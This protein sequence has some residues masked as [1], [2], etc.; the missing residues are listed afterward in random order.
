LR[1]RRILGVLGALLFAAVLHRFGFRRSFEALLAADRV[2]LLLAV[3]AFL[4]SQAVRLAKWEFFHRAAGLSVDRAS[5]GRLYFHIKLLGTITPGRVGEFLPAMAAPASR[6]PLLS[7]T[8]YDRLIESLATLLLAL[9]A[10]VFLLQ[11]K[12]PAAFL[13]V[14]L[15]LLLLLAAALLLCVRSSWMER[16]AGWLEGRRESRP[17]GLF[18]SLLRPET[19]IAEGIAGL[20]ASFRSLFRPG[21]AAAAFLLT[22][23]AVGADLLF[24]WLTFRSVGIALSAG[25]L[26]G[27]V[28]L[29]NV[30]GFFSPT[31][32]GLGVS[33]A[34][35]V[36]FLRSAGADGPFGSF[37][38]L[39]R[40][41]VL[42]VTALAAWAF[43][44]RLA[45]AKRGNDS[46]HEPTG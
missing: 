28:A 31:P 11:A 39:L 7:F 19:R 10:F 5:L 9:G 44:A 40:L 8:A 34:A 18:A 2:S 20:R 30:T 42:V 45:L 22:L 27:A 15:V 12:A 24:W 46:K 29:F 6:G 1:G 37:L 25:L 35:F 13:P 23:L 17:G 14:S 16:V 41:I 3:L 21:A 33:D 4:L 38:L 32:G 26:V 36:I 43:S